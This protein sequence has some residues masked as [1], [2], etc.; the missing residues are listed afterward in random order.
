[1]HPASELP[2]P[3]CFKGGVT[4][5]CSR[6]NEAV[7]VMF[8]SIRF[9]TK[10]NSLKACHRANDHH[11]IAFDHLHKLYRDGKPIHLIHSA[12]DEFE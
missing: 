4:L 2:D 5:A 7:S 3:W 11:D 12:V 8:K 10:L 6:A 9:C 1:M